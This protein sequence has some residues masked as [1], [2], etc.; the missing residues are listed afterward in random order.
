MMELI[1]LF[2]IG[3]YVCLVGVN[4]SLQKLDN[5][6]LKNVRFSNFVTTNLL[7]Q[8]TFTSI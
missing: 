6:N 2:R 3:R 7:L 8:T 4:I 1:L 5:E